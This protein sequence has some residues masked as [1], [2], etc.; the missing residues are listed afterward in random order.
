MSRQWIKAS[1][2]D[3]DGNILAVANSHGV[4]LYEVSENMIWPIHTMN[5]EHK[6]SDHVRNISV[7]EKWIAVSYYNTS[8][9]RA[10]SYYDTLS[11]RVWIP[12]A[13]CKTVFFNAQ[14][15]IFSVC[16]GYLVVY[17]KDRSIC[18]Y[19]LNDNTNYMF[20]GP[21]G[22]VVKSLKTLSN[23]R[24]V[25]G[26]MDGEILTFECSRPTIVANSKVLTNKSERKG[27]N[28]LIMSDSDKDR[29]EMVRIVK[30]IGAIPVMKIDREND[31]RKLS[32]VVSPVWVGSEN[33]GVTKKIPV[34]TYEEF[35]KEVVVIDEVMEVASF[36]DL[37]VSGHMSGL[38]SLWNYK[39]NEHYS[40]NHANLIQSVSMSDK[41]IC[42]ITIGQTIKVWSKTMQLTHTFKLS[43]RTD[44]FYK[45]Y[46]YADKVSCISRDDKFDRLFGTCHL[47]M[48]SLS[49]MSREIL[50]LHQL[51][52]ALMTAAKENESDMKTLLS[53][54]NENESDKMADKISKKDKECM[55]EENDRLEAEVKRLKTK[56]DDNVAKIKKYNEDQEKT[57][58]F[59]IHTFKGYTNIPINQVESSAYS[60]EFDEL[61]KLLPTAVRLPGE[62]TYVTRGAELIGYIHVQQETESYEDEDGKT[63]WYNIYEIVSVHGFVSKLI[64]KLKGNVDDDDMSRIIIKE[65]RKK[66][67]GALFSAFVKD[68]DFHDG[69]GNKLTNKEHDDYELMW[70][71]H[72]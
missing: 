56:I 45:L 11:V 71:D 47:E 19:N 7:C 55:Q 44:G 32:C 14:V 3:M 21:D 57:V 9:V 49:N 25:I 38:V 41:M 60:E 34:L 23:G 59:Y 51:K 36:G 28:V 15:E 27:K 70:P 12:S 18:V 53:G 2:V 52:N 26:M 5:H 29:D 22:R 30:G 48:I 54:A 24:V 67:G 10:E 39:T 64:R 66:L 13:V 43:Y 6:E 37:I 46:A 4:H 50:P 20:S 65:P 33:L 61:K 69:H 62:H 1:V 68:L 35:L 72:H 42:S 17:M 40:N 8:C 16:P 31:V 58:R 63:C